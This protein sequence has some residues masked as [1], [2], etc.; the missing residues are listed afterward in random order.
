MC[1]CTEWVGWREGCKGMLTF[2]RQVCT[3]HVCVCVCV[4]CLVALTSFTSS[5]D[6]VSYETI[7]ALIHTRHGSIV[8]ECGQ[9]TGCRRGR[10]GGARQSQT[11]HSVTVELLKRDPK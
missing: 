2:I 1:V 5:S 9:C 4:L 10:E 7:W 3:V 8:Q 6:V 11:Q